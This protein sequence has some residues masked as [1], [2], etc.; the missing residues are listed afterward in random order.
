M[1][2]LKEINNKIEKVMLLLGAICFAF[3]LIACFLQFFTRYVMGNAASWTEESARFAMCWVSMLGSAVLLRHGGH[4][5]MT[6]V[7]GKLKNEK[8]KL[9][10]N[11]IAEIVVLV[12]LYF[13]TVYGYQSTLSATKQIS[14]V[15]HLNYGFVY[16]CVPV[17]GVLMILF[18]IE[19]ILAL[20]GE[21][22]KK[23]AK[24]VD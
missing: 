4:V 21:Y 19:R 5:S 18:T 14:P 12:F 17:A 11:V 8:A 10:I 3:M 15:L 9:V 22:K 16:A 13:M 2:G 24:E 23:N 7:T 20:F 6:L 1:T